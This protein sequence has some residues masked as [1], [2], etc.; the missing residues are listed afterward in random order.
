MNKVL[1]VLLIMLIGSL[2]IFA[3]DPTEKITSFRESVLPKYNIYFTNAE[4][5]ESGQLTLSAGEKYKL[6]SLSGKKAIM[7]NLVKSWQE[8]LVLVHYESK[9][10]L[11]VWDS[12]TGKAFLLDWWDI[13]ATA[14]PKTTLSTGSKTAL[15]PWFV[16][17]G[18]QGQ[19]DKNHEVNG[20]L[21]TRIG[22]FLLRNRWDFAW[23]FSGGLL[24]NI[25]SE[26]PMT[27]RFSTGLMSKVYFPVKK[28]N[29]SPNVG[30]DI[31]STTYTSSETVANTHNQSVSLLAGISWYIGHGSL[32]VGFRIGNEF[33]TMIGY[34]Y[35]P[36]FKNRKKK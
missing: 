19:M 25:D 26:V 11:W 4:L 14:V 33:T 34:T 1:N 30:I 28:L 5:T 21:N 10:E 35:I 7:D 29:M 2:Q 31:A 9:R 6:L 27:S 36:Q 20:A 16:Y 17:L 24:G 18:G 12:E 23:T 8:S 32:D 22:F 13:N 3:Q 15:H